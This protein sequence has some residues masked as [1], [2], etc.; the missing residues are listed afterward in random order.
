MPDDDE[1]PASAIDL[2]FL[3]QAPDEVPGHVQVA[4]GVQAQV[5]RD[6]AKRMPSGEFS[7]YF[8]TVGAALPL[9]AG[10][11]RVRGLDLF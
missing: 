11:G 1:E 6:G 2:L 8:E 10:E 3:S 9:P 5:H 4:A 7:G